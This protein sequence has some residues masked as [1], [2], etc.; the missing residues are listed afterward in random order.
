MS[1]GCRAVDLNAYVFSFFFSSSK[2]LT[3]R[4]FRWIGT[5]QKRTLSCVKRTTCVEDNRLISH[6]VVCDWL[7]CDTSK[8]LNKCAN[9]QS[10]M[11]KHCAYGHDWVWDSEVSKMWSMKAA[12]Q[13]HWFPWLWPYENSSI[14][15]LIPKTI[16]N[17]KRDC[18]WGCAR[19]INTIWENLQIEK[20][21]TVRWVERTPSWFVLFDLQIFS[22]SVYP[23]SAT[24]R[25]I[26]FSIFFLF[27]LLFS[28]FYFLSSFFFFFSICRF[29]QVVFIPRA[30]PHA[31]SF[32]YFQ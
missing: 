26:F 5:D 20:H 10:H 30:Q 27:Y 19:G 6:N 29:S 2:W 11:L 32:F 22:D 14:D 23:P 9:T 21:K 18:A 8:S 28:I 25:T 4:I 16:G 24:S 17:R 31:Q 13:L 15:R 3:P 12:I 1:V 7:H